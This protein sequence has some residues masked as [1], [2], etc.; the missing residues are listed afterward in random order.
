M[1]VSVAGSA[2]VAGAQGVRIHRGVAAP[3][4]L[5]FSTWPPPSLLKHRITEEQLAKEKYCNETK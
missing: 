3:F 4:G 5:T 2:S 1:R